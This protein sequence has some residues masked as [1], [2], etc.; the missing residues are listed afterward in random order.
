MYNLA[1]GF[2]NLSILENLDISNNDLSH[3]GIEFFVHQGLVAGNP[4]AIHGKECDSSQD[5]DSYC[6]ARVPF[7]SKKNQIKPDVLKGL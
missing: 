7:A 2:K 1:P 6:A 4:P 5:D 3:F